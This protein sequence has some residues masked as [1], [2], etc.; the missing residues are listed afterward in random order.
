MIELPDPNKSGSKIQNNLGSVF[1]DITMHL[2][3]AD[4]IRKHMTNSTDIRE[5][6]LNG[7]DLSNAKKI[8]DL[9]C[10]YGFFT[11]GLKGKVNKNAEILGIDRHSKC[12]Q[13]YLNACLE[14]G[15]KGR[16]ISNS[17]S[18]I[19]SIKGKSVDLVICSFALYFFPEYIK[20]ISR[21]LKDDGYFITITHSY[22]HMLELTNYIK[23]I[24]TRIGLETYENLP[25]EEL[26]QGFS[27][28]NGKE[29]LSACFGE[30][31]RKKIVSSLLF[32]YEDYNHF[33]KYFRFKKSFFIPNNNLDQDKLTEIILEELRDDMRKYGE[34]KISKEDMIFVCKRSL[35]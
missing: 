10:G 5:T 34:L 27:D 28:A 6:A 8:V 16:F 26:I 17:I 15:I 2:E 1:C 3:V 14:T 7:I 22:P 19:E 29:L 21:I 13:H 4:I 30:I 12:E 25:Y 11:K 20:Q 24:F 31:T 9:G 32:K 33:E 18:E 35:F 23:K